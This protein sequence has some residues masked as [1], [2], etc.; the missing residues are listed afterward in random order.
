MRTLHARENYTEKLIGIISLENLIS[1]TK[2]NVIGIIF[3]R[4]SGW[5][6]LRSEELQNKNP[7]L[8]RLFISKFGTTNALSTLPELLKMFDTLFR[9]KERH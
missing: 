9:G 5:S 4:M 6:V 7:Q 1:V 8:C 2:V 3:A